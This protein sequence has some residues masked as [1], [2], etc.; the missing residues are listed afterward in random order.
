MSVYIDI[1]THRAYAQKTGVLALQNITLSNQEMNLDKWL[2]AGWHPWYIQNTSLQKIKESIN[3]AAAV[4]NVVAIGECGIDRS[5][6]TPVD[7][8]AEVF[9]YHVEVAAE[10][11]K[12]LIIHCVK[13]Y[14]DINGLLKKTNFKLP[15]IFHAYNGNKIQTQQLLSLNAYFSIGN[16]ISYSA[17]KLSNILSEVPLS[18]LF[19]ETDDSTYSIENNY[20]E[21]AD[22]LKISLYDLKNQIE[23]NF[24]KI[25]GNEL[26]STY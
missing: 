17:K 10:K 12:P 4:K 24:I 13:A 18:R 15:V 22:I 19:I 16:P 23:I 2:T 5:I 26:V 6:D 8:Q 7:T 9:K 1:H 20:Q 25:F 3:H 11:Q 14:S 21:I